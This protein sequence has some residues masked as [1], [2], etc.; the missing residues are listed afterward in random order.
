MQKFIMGS[1][2]YNIVATV[3]LVMNF[4]RT[5]SIQDPCSICPA[6][7]F[8]TKKAC[9]STS[10]AECEC[11]SGFHCVGAGCT[12][13]REDC[14]RG[15]ELTKDGC[16]DCEFGKF[17][18]QKH[19]SCQL[20]TDC[21]LHGKSV[22]VNGTKESD[23]VCGPTSKDF[24]PGQTSQVTI[25]FLALTSTAMFFLVL[26]LVLHFSVTKH[27]KKKLLYIFK[28]PFVRTVQTAQEE[29]ACSC[30]FP[31]EEEGEREL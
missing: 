23:V 7:V 31:E 6:G 30:R 13:C 28:Q 5:R 12:K 10:N 21:S 16:K 14:K 27:S 1:G 3:L 19:G 11:V 25:C 26:F 18:D 4:E 29:D 9:S 24:S 8:W 22:H 17:N 20:W 15:Q 2:Y